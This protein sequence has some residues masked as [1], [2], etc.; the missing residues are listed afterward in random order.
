MSSLDHGNNYEG[1]ADHA[2]DHGHDYEHQEEAAAVTAPQGKP[3]YWRSLNELERTP[4]FQKALANEFAS[5]NASVLGSDFSRRRFLQL[6]GASVVLA[7]ASGCWK[8]TKIVAD[9]KLPPD[10]V[11]GVPQYF[12]TSRELG[13]AAIGL[14]VKCVEGRPVKVEG[15]PLHP[16]NGDGK[17]VGT[18]DVF[19]LASILELY[20]PERSREVV[21]RE[22]GKRTA[23]KWADFDTAA[24]GL[25]K[26]LRDKKGAGLRIL[27]EG[28]LSPTILRLKEKLLKAL[29]EAG[30]VEYEP[31]SDDNVR[32]GAKLA[33]GN[34]VRTHYKFNEADLVL[35]LDGDPLTQHGAAL[36][37]ALDF[38]GKRKL[39]GDGA[40]ATMNR[41]YAVESTFSTLGATADHRLPLRSEQIKPFLLALSAAVGEASHG[42]IKLDVAAKNDGFL[43]DEKVKK[44]VGAL[45]KDLFAN[46]GKSIVYVGD[47]QPAEVHALAHQLNDALGNAG[48]TISYTAEINADRQPYAAAIKALALEMSGGKVDTLVIL[49]GNP[50]YN[51]PAD[52]DFAAAIAKV[53]NSIRFG[54]HEDETS[55]LCSWHVPKAHYFESW[56]DA[57]AWDG[58]V[59]LVQP[60]I[61]PLYDGKSA[62]EVL[63]FIGDGAW[64]SGEELVKETFKSLGGKDASDFAWRKALHDGVVANTGLKAETPKL[65]QIKTTEVAARAMQVDAGAGQLEGVFLA[66]TKVYDGRFANNAWLQELPDYIT[67]MTW[68]NA[69]FFSNKTAEALG[70][71]NQDLVTLS[72][73]GKSVE[74][75][76]YIL[77]GQAP[78]SVGLVLGYGRTAA[79][80]VGGNAEVSVGFNI[81]KLRTSEAPNVVTGLSAAATG[82]TYKLAL[83][84]DHHLIDNAG[85]KRRED[86]LRE[87]AREGTLSEYHKH[88]DFAQH[89][90]HHPPLESLWKEFEYKGH[91]WGLAVDLHACI[92]C[93]SCMTACQSENNVPVVGKDQV[94]RGREMH[95]MRLDRYYKG[96]VESPEMVTQPMLCQQCE[97]AP[98]E[99][100]CPV[101]ATMHSREGLNDMVYNRCIG[102]RYCANNCPYKVRRFNWLDWNKNLYDPKNEALKLSKNPD[103]TVRMRGVME[104][105]TY[106]V[107]RIE[108]VKIQTKNAGKPILDGMI[109]PACAQACPTQAITFGDLNDK[110]S[111]VRRLHAD[112]R[113]YGLLAELNVKPR[114]GYLARIRNYNPELVSEK[115][116]EHGHGHH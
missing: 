53:P 33:F 3:L 72:V 116:D 64:K 14:L 26:G 12:A 81:Y 49:G 58:T 96:D 38:S 21:R 110:D 84:Q 85:M 91:R 13:G 39:H 29:P 46:A 92:G 42:K 106:C 23:Q 60:L 41:V 59:S 87:I 79:G 86:S 20:D 8:E 105:C 80:S 76:A 99:Q 43:A 111:A 78:G 98:C 10:R 2:H 97:N 22:G 67:K 62:V 61:A 57:R 71:K 107:Q 66:D 68:D 7:G 6:M 15:N 104:K 90:V 32:E 109:V 82:K 113:A 48:K 69:A 30:W 54:L 56:G 11:P 37:H 34:V 55:Q 70:I 47:R 94:L 9:P 101:G 1:H 35:A 63:S 95:W 51:A 102:T 88:P 24:A 5:D 44:F 65:Q 25:F 89:M 31:I 100:V 4:E 27:S 115:A 75:A 19:A 36:R 16:T 40:H 73:G 18:V 114:T 103:V 112:P 17:A 52:A 74:C 28:S 45:A 83:T 77:P 108:A 93:N 50:A